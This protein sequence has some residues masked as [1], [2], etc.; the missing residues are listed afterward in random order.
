MPNA[1]IRTQ[2]APDLDEELDGVEPRLPKRMARLV[3]KVRSPGAAAFRIPLG[4]ALIAAGFVGFL[5]ILGFW[6]APLGLAIIA[7]D[8]P[9][10]RR[11]LARALAWINRRWKP[12]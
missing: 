5:P 8:V 9:F 2:N 6:M 4:I 1:P 12:A 10:L 11:P 3:H 7:Q